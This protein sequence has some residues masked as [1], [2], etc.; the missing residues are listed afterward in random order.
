MTYGT[1]FV[2]CMSKQRGVKSN[3]HNHEDM[4]GVAL[5]IN[6]MPKALRAH[7]VQK[8]KLYNLEN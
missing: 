6:N 1:G 5:V 4:A 8:I 3:D 2:P 7:K